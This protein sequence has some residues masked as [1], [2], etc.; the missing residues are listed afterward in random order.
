L[1]ARC[2]S[3]RPDERPAD[4]GELAAQLGQLGGLDTVVDRASPPRPSLTRAERKLLSVVLIGGGEGAFETIV[5]S[6]AGAGMI[7]S[8]PDSE[9]S[10]APTTSSEGGGDTQ[11]LAALR[12][13]AAAHGG[14]LERLVDGSHVVTITGG[15]T[16]GDQA[17]QAARCALALKVIAPAAPIALA[18][19]RAVLAGR[20]PVGEVI[21][22]AAR[23]IG[24]PDPGAVVASAAGPGMISVRIDDVTAGL[25]DVRFEIG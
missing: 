14:S 1:V 12:E 23:L 17:A 7:V 20:W 9:I 5:A 13:G 22:R 25:L 10:S 4:G 6:G 16:A 18:T 24:A 11:V 8:G 3:K 21:D 15:G 19:G 2:L